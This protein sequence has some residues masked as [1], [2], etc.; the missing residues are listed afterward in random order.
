MDTSFL[1]SNYVGDKE[2]VRRIIWLSQKFKDYKLE[3]SYF[4]QTESGIKDE[5]DKQNIMYEIKHGPYHDSYAED[6]CDYIIYLNLNANH[7]LLGQ[8]ILKFKID[9]AKKEIPN[10]I[11]CVNEPI[12]CYI[13]RTV[14]LNDD[15]IYITDKPEEL[16]RDIYNNV[17]QHYEPTTVKLQI[18]NTMME[19]SV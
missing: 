19:V 14:M 5:L 1:N 15:Y 7:R 17:Y 11:F 9:I 10:I 2:F 13:L 4:Y 3:F 6:S 8:R 18:G 12:S 16:L